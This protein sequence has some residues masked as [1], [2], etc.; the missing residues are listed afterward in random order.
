MPQNTM[1]SDLDVPWLDD[2][3]QTESMKRDLLNRIARAEAYVNKWRS[4]LNALL[5]AEEVNHREYRGVKKP[6][7]HLVLKK[8]LRKTGN[9][10]VTIDEA[11][12]ISRPG[13]GIRGEQEFWK[14]INRCLDTGT[15]EDHDGMIKLPER[16]KRK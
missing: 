14:S 11:K 8:H 12:E 4:V 9:K 13:W 7:P 5:K 15:L 10:G 2:R 16:A 6:R 1:Q 3:E